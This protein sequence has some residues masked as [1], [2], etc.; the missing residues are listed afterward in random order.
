MP[1]ALIKKFERMINDTML[2]LAAYETNEDTVFFA[3][4]F[5]DEELVW[6]SIYDDFLTATDLALDVNFTHKMVQA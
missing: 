6:D 2:M 3:N 5:I 4:G 1:K